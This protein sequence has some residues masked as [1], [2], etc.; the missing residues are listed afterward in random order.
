MARALQRFSVRTA[1]LAGFGALL[2]LIGL[3]LAVVLVQGSKLEANFVLR[4]PLDSF[5]DLPQEKAA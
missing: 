5:D 4:L 3:A 1:I 2:L